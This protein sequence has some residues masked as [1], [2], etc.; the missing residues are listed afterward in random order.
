[1]KIYANIFT[2]V[3]GAV[4]ALCPSAALAQVVINEIAWMGNASNANAEWIELR[5][6]S[7]SPISLEGW[8]LAAEDGSPVMTLAGT[9]SGNGFFLLERTGDESV[10]GVPA[11]LMY[12]GALGN[13]G[14]TLTLKD[15]SGQVIDTVVGGEQWADVGGD[16]VTKETAQRGASGWITAPL[17]PRSG[18]ASASTETDPPIDTV[19]E[20]T[21][22]GATPGS[23]SGSGSITPA[24]SSAPVARASAGKD[25]VVVVGVDNRFEGV[26]YDAGDRPIEHAR[27][28]WNFGDGTTAE[29]RVV[30]HQWEYP[31]RYALVLEVSRFESKVSHR[32]TVTAEIAQISFEV[33]E[34]GGI[35]L[36]NLSNRDVDLSLWRISDRGIVFTFSS[37]TIL[38]KSGS[39]RLSPSAL[40]FNASPQ[41]ELLY[42]DGSIAASVSPTPSTHTSA[43]AANLI[44]DEEHP[45]AASS[46]EA[47]APVIEVVSSDD[48]EDTVI[49]SEVIPAL[50]VVR[51]ESPPENIEHAAAVALT[52]DTRGTSVLWWLGVLLVAGL[53][54]SAIYVARHLR[55]KEWNIIEETGND[56]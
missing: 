47:V 15:S 18:N 55:R 50:S 38:L 36:K 12:T 6:T 11:D 16:N 10:P 32:V 44:E 37:N 40:R 20:N 14:E 19:D 35:T 7:A 46:T 21:D 25:R 52:V 22:S 13:A 27:F 31:G 53:G 5:N 2:I 45:S 41:A 33:A 49:V 30:M 24:P 4:I 28:L 1:M 54:C 17:T 48:T 9:I 43:Q 26:A 3:Y 34:D 39:I 51:E 23:T 42:P 29:G 56:V 8:T